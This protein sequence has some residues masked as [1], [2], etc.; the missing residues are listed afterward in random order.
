MDILDN[1][2]IFNLPKVLCA[3]VMTT[4]TLFFL[5]KK[6]NINLF[7]SFVHIFKRDGGAQSIA[8]IPLNRFPKEASDSIIF[9]FAIWGI[10]QFLM[11]MIY[12]AI[13]WKYQTLLPF[14]TLHFTLENIFRILLKTFTD[15]KMVT[16]KRP[17]AAI[18]N[19]V[20]VPLGIFLFW[21]SLPTFKN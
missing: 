1:N 6:S 4:Y 16:E 7:F 2:S 14:G 13:L 8:T 17:P 3:K 12:S 19:I 15:K 5:E 18:L 11:A 9:I 20:F 21:N 10:S